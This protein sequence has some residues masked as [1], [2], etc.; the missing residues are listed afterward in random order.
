MK[1]KVEI[2]KCLCNKM[3]K[4]TNI[5][6][7]NICQVPVI[8]PIFNTFMTRKASDGILA[9]FLHKREEHGNKVVIC[10]ASANYNNRLWLI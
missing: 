9:S 5:D 1:Y 7:P 10:V 3:S 8:I 4:G 2:P 6:W